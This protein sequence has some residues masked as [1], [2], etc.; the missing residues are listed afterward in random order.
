MHSIF[1]E[2]DVESPFDNF[3][4]TKKSNPS[5]A[6]RLLLLAE[7]LL[8]GLKLFLCDFTKRFGKGIKCF[9]NDQV[10]TA[11]RFFRCFKQIVL[12][13]VGSCFTF[14]SESLINFSRFEIV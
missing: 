12:P 3:V 7:M 6:M 9:A 4:Q 13:V 8:Y 1:L 10:N 14:H 5:S 2:H 11:G